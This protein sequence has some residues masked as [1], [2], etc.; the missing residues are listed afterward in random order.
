M[1]GWVIFLNFFLNLS[2][3]S[4]SSESQG[5]CH[6]RGSSENMLHSG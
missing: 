2:S 4:V 6:F 5:H 3:I 1:S